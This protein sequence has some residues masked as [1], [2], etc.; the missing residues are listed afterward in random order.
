MAAYISKRAFVN[1]VNLHYIVAGA[2]P[3]ALGMRGWPQNHRE[4]L[5]L[6]E[7]LAGQCRFIVPDLRGFVDSDKSFSGYEPKTIAQDMLELLAAEACFSGPAQLFGPADHIGVRFLRGLQTI[8]KNGR[9]RHWKNAK[10]LGSLRSMPGIGPAGPPH[11]IH[12]VRRTSCLQYSKS[13]IGKDTISL[14][15]RITCCIYS[16][17]L[18]GLPV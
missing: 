15:G 12:Y 11:Y 16:L 13:A 9:L 8:R 14:P 18:I 7:K 10:K 4:Y 17:C 6:I 1:E 3:V 5:Q 2:G